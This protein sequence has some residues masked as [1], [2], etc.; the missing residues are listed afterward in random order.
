MSRTAWLAPLVNTRIARGVADAG[1]VQLAHR[2]VKQLDQINVAKVQANT[3]LKLVR[4]AQDTKFGRDHDFAHIGSVADYQARVPI[5]DYDDFWTTY[6]KEAYPSLS[7]VTWP[8]FIPYYALSSGTTSG[9]T[10]FLPVS[11][12][13]VK[14]NM[15]AGLTTLALFRHAYPK[16]KTFNG[17]FFFLG[18]STELRAQADGSFAGDLSGIAAKEVKD[19]QRPFTFPSLEMSLITDWE[20]KLRRLS[21][22]S[23]RESITAV[24]GVPSWMLLL[25]N[26][27]KEVTGKSRLIDAWPGGFFEESFNEMF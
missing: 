3:L 10:K 27:V 1:F 22:Q 7:S 24:S 21:E 15:K 26:H 2:R 17:K 9:T 23:L 14:S 12:E 18:G 13:M 6:W 19:V 8:T 11:T 20:V 4:F 25:F 16:A 5:R